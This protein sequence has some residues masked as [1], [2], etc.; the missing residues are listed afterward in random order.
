V[1]RASFDVETEEGGS[2][3]LTIPF[4]RDLLIDAPVAGGDIHDIS[5]A[6]GVQIITESAVYRPGKRTFD[7]SIKF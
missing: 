3:D 1:N 4:I 7:G 5:G 2:I 6:L